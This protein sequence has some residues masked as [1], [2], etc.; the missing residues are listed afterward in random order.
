M[1]SA[2]WTRYRPDEALPAGT[3]VVVADNASAGTVATD[4]LEPVRRVVSE[5]TF[6]VRVVDL[7][8]N[9]GLYAETLGM[10]PFGVR[11]GPLESAT[12]YRVRGTPEAP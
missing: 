12:L 5:D 10:L 7:A 6:P 8:G 4:V 3:W 9:V 2:G 1:E 11:R